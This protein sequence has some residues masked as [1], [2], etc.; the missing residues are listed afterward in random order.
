MVAH[1][2][3][4]AQGNLGG[5]A[6]HPQAITIRGTEGVA[7][8]LASCC[9]PIPG[10]PILGFI[11]KDRGLIIHTHDCPAI[12]NFRADPDKW[13]DVEWEPQ[14]DRLFDVAIKLVVANKRGVLG[15][16]A[17]AISDQGSNIGNV[18]MEEEDGSPYTI[19]YFTLQVEDRLHLARIMRGL[20]QL[21][22]VVRI[23]RVKG[24]KDGRAQGQ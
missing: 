1:Q 5:A 3:L 2:L 14:K 13:L 21:Q 12:R 24:R 19:L 10:D 7:V 8:E 11:H 16:V 6:P 23:F 18:S 22:D 17:S 20:R 9:H 4:H 15:R